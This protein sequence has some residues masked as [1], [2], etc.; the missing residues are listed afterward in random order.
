MLRRYR[1][2]MNLV[3]TS[4]I[5]FINIISQQKSSAEHRPHIM[6]EEQTFFNP[7]K[8]TEFLQL[9]KCGL[10]ID[11]GPPKLASFVVATRERLLPNIPYCFYSK[12]LYDDNK[13][14]FKYQKIFLLFQSW[15]LSQVINHDDVKKQWTKRGTLIDARP[16]YE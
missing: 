10:S 16:E 4:K 3:Q 9:L 15:T 2:L 8:S 7:P 5:Y 12:Y 13:Q 1:K 11:R 6:G 14:A